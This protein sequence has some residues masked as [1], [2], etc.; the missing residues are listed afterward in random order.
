MPKT[1]AQIQAT[2]SARVKAIRDDKQLTPE[3]RR[4]LLAKLYV[5]GKR[6]VVTVARQN[7]AAGNTRRDAIERAMFGI[8]GIRGTDRASLAASYRDAQDRAASVKSTEQAA[9][10]LDRA[11]RSGDEPL[12]RA[13]AAHAYDQLTTGMGRFSRAGAAEWERVLNGYLATRS[14]LDSEADELAR[15]NQPVSNLFAGHVNRPDELF[16]LDD[17]QV[18]SLAESAEATANHAA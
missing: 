10:L 14:D 11:M 6:E 3:A 17:K 2:Y 8:D 5:D 12:A 13:V 18:Q 15:L 9:S 7:E 4:H 16:G 1:S